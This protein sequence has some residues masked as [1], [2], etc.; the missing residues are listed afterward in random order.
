M[1]H[2]SPRV[3]I[4]IEVGKLVVKCADTPHEL[5]EALRL[6]HDVFYSEMAGKRLESG[7]D[8][9]EF[10]VDSDHLIIAERET[11][12]VVGTYRIRCS[13]YVDRFYSETEF[14][15]DGF[16]REF[17][18]TKMEIGRACV[19]PSYRKGTVNQ[20]LWRGLIEY[21]V[22]SES[23]LLF[24]CSSL[25]T[26]DPGKVAS[27]Y[28]ELKRSD[29]LIDADWVRPRIPSPEPFVPSGGV[30][31]IP[32]LLQFYLRAGARLIGR[33]AWDHELKCVDFFT[34]LD[35]AQATEKYSRKYVAC[36]N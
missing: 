2:P 32:P 30:A 28:E 29:Q 4:R 1:H 35:L 14:E 16:L 9:D 13:R 12:R 34:V 22:K 33:P 36:S 11:S 19:H 7:I 6:R 20:L 21:A 24:G 10:D 18:G 3:S 17:G 27:A 26:V 31:E 8:T 25:P 5:E 23:R 15:I